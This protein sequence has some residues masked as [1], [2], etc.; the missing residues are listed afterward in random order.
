[1]ADIGIAGH[2]YVCLYTSKECTI[3]LITVPSAPHNFNTT[4]TCVILSVALTW[5]R[6]DPP[7]GL[8]TKYNV[9]GITNSYCLKLSLL[10]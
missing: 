9:S 10:S 4:N 1:M 3:N 5:S 6:P 2:I 8:I 7:N